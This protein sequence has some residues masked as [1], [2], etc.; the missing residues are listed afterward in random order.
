MSKWQS[1]DLDTAITSLGIMLIVL[2]DKIQEW[3]SLPSNVVYAAIIFIFS[4]Q[5]FIWFKNRK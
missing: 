1:N 2:A 4:I 3:T 5:I